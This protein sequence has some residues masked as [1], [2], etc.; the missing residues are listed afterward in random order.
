MHEQ[1][2]EL[3]WSHRPWRLLPFA[4]AV[5]ACVVALPVELA[6]ALRS[7]GG[8]SAWLALAAGLTIS[9]ALS[10]LLRASWLRGPHRCDLLFSELLLWSWLADVYRQRR[11]R[12]ACKVLSKLEASQTEAR[13]T[14]LP[15]SA[16]WRIVRQLAAAVDG[17][18]VYLRGHSRRVTRHAVAISRRMGL[19]PTQ[20]ACIRAAA[21]V[22][23]VGKLRVPRELVDKPGRLAD[24]ELV[25]INRHATEGARIVAVLGDS[26]LTAIVRHHHERFD[27]RGYPNGLVAKQIPLGARIIAVADTFDA[28]TS[29]RPYRRAARRSEAVA[30]L[31]RCS[32]TQLDPEVVKAFLS[33]YARRRPALLLAST[34]TAPQ[35]ALARLG[36]DGPRARGAAVANA[37][38]IFAATAAVA[39][40]AV[41][42]S[43]AAPRALTPPVRRVPQ[44]VV[45]QVL[46]LHPLHITGG[47][48]GTFWQAIS[49]EVA[50]GRVRPPHHRKKRR[51][52]HPTRRRNPSKRNLHRQRPPRMT[53]TSKP[54][55]AP[56]RRPAQPSAIGAP[57]PPQAE[58]PRSGSGGTAV[59]GRVPGG[60]ARPG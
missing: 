31:R 49:A 5:T 53:P 52:H 26:E 54:R 30:T 8:A 47:T 51:P 37:A 48:L 10:W 7:H 12:Q 46:V 56:A 20:L 40:S 33:C 36:G 29:V 27:G 28:V 41:T 14:R 60:T 15:R 4:L 58:A 3:G 1:V 18:D 59:T 2:G 23:D 34:L 11:F 25:Q 55:P 44:F 22:H 38:T 43:Q 16:R 9:L 42:P 57:P 50:S 19:P 6:W 35:R 21:T 24:E 17:Q 32:G 45:R 39:A 13:E